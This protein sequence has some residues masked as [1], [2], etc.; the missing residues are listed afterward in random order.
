M[1]EKFISILFFLSLYVGSAMAYDIYFEYLDKDYGTSFKTNVEESATFVFNGKIDPERGL[2]SFYYL[3]YPNQVK[4]KNYVLGVGVDEYKNG[5]QHFKTC[6]NDVR[7]IAN[8]YNSYFSN[9]CILTNNFATKDSV[10]Q[11]IVDISNELEKGDNFLFFYSGYANSNS[12]LS[13]YDADYTSS[14]FLEDFAKFKEGVNIIIMLDSVNVSA[15]LDAL[16]SDFVNSPNVLLFAGSKTPTKKYSERLSPFTFAW[17]KTK[18]YLTD[19]NKDQFLTF[20]EMACRIKLFLAKNKIKESFFFSNETLA[21]GIIYYNTMLAEDYGEIS[22]NEDGGQFTIAASNIDNYARIHIET[23]KRFVHDIAICPKKGSFNVNLKKDSH[24]TKFSLEFD[25]S[26]LPEDNLSLT[27]NNVLIPT[28]KQ[29]KAN[30]NG[31]S[32]TYTIEDYNYKKVG[33]LKF[34][35]ENEVYHCKLNI[36]GMNELANVLEAATGVERIDLLVRFTEQMNNS[37]LSFDKKY[38][39]GKSLSAKLIN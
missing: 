25:T 18:D 34:K 30:K 39:P 32:G 15:F 33:A 17:Y 19:E 28:F 13:F 37:K 27:M 36:N 14:E 23:Q 21:K 3:K 38:T 22:F 7:N 20:Y 4:L 8:P 31:K 11:K 29:Q 16:S 35:K 26:Y 1:I 6:A 24:P 5:N 9:S 10:R 2:T 12:A